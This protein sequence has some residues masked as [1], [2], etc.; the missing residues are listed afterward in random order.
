[1][2][3]RTLKDLWRVVLRR[4]EIPIMSNI[5]FKMHEKY[6]VEIRQLG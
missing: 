1:M 5:V 2:F 4:S 6:F 3:L